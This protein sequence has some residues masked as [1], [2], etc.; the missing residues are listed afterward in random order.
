MKKFH[1][2]KH[3]VKFVLKKRRHHDD[4]YWD[5]LDRLYYSAPK[6]DVRH[7]NVAHRRLEKR[8]LY[9]ILYENANECEL[10]FPY[11]HR[12]SAS[13]NYW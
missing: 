8:L 6:R 12:H 1:N 3:K 4:R 2:W 13:W 5:S 9:K 7:Y 10:H 11:R